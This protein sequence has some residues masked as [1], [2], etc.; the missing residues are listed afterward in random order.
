MTWESKHRDFGWRT[1]ITPPPFFCF[2]FLFFKALYNIIMAAI[3]EKIAKLAIPAGLAVGGI[4][5]AMYDGKFLFLFIYLE[6]L[7]FDIFG[8]KIL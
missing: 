2:R 8:V 1:K 5:S 6:L 3:L 4:Q 7:F